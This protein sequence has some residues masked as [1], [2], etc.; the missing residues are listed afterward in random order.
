MNIPEFQRAIE[1]ALD[2]HER[3]VRDARDQLVEDL[4]KAKALL[5][6]EQDSIA[7]EMKR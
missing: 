7:V 6:E 1:L 2:K 4:Y 5:L 3:A